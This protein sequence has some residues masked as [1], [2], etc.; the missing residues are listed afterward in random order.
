MIFKEYY[1]ELIHASRQITTFRQAIAKKTIES[2]VLDTINPSV[3]N[4]LLLAHLIASSLLRRIDRKLLESKNIYV[5]EFDVSQISLF[6]SMKEAVPF[7]EA[8]NSIANQH[9]QR[10][11]TKH[12]TATIFDIGC[13]KGIQVINLIKSLLNNPND[14]R[15]LK[16][17][18]I[19]PIPDNLVSLQD[20]ISELGNTSL[21]LEFVAIN[22]LI[23]DLL[24]NN[25][26]HLK[27]LSEGGFFINSTFTFHHT[28]HPLTDESFRTKLFKKLRE[29]NPVLFTLAEPHSNHDTEELPRRL[30]NAWNHFG[31][32]FD[33]IDEANIGID[34]KFLIKEKFFG[35]EIRDVFGVSDQFRSERHEHFDSW[36]LRLHR[37]G[38]VPV[39]KSDIT[40]VLPD[41]CRSHISDGLT[42]LN[43][44]NEV[45]VG[46]MAYN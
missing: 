36:I 6:Y 41:H 19:D 16:I 18:A 4:G 2:F 35:R 34:H 21:E 25:Y 14:L 37:A 15:R 23:E 5:E 1:E 42:R 22:G 8:A 33:L 20:K 7:V 26:E 43:Y 17:L 13:G 27:S 10:E 30:H 24:V 44:R 38:F 29:M 46:V 32:V 28:S 12:H 40:V 3:P 39:S 11:I 31:L 45:I 9:I